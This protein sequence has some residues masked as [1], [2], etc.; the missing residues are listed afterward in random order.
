VIGAEVARDRYEPLI[1]SLARKL[2]MEFGVEWRR[3]EVRPE[4]HRRAFQTT[5]WVIDQPLTRFPEWE[6]RLDATVTQ[7]F[8]IVGAGTS[9]AVLDAAL[10]GLDDQP[11]SETHAPSTDQHLGLDDVVWFD[12]ENPL[13]LPLTWTVR[14][15]L[16]ADIKVAVHDDRTNLWAAASVKPH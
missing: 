6:R 14:D 16:G 15:R 1:E 10:Q 12:G 9:V 4:K 11:P 7:V 5:R 13:F 8:D 3:A 2:S